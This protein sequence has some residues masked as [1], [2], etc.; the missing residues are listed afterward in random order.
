MTVIPSCCRAIPDRGH[1]AWPCGSLRRVLE[2]TAE[3]YS[4]KETFRDWVA[5]Q[6]DY[7]RETIEKALV[8]ML[9]STVEAT[10]SSST[11]PSDGGP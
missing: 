9:R 8:D 3:P 10:Y 6:M 2:A 5:N 7:G 11:L 1:D 4:F